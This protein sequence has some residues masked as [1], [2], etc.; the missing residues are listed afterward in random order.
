MLYRGEILVENF[1]S[2]SALFKEESAYGAFVALSEQFYDKNMHDN[3]ESFYSIYSSCLFP[4]DPWYDLLSMHMQNVD[5][6]LYQV[7]CSTCCNLY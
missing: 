2:F 4:F 7:N 1:S 6:H 5:D 3:F